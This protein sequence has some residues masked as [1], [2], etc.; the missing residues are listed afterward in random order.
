MPRNILIVVAHEDDEILG[1]GGTISR[2]IK[3]G[4]KV[5]VCFLTHDSPTRENEITDIALE[6]HKLIGIEKSFVASY[7]CM[8]LKDEYHFDIVRFIENAIRQSNADVVITHHPYDLHCDH[9]VVSKCCQEAVRL[10]QRK[11]GYNHEVKAFMYMEVKSST[12]WSLNDGMNMFVPNFFVGIN[13]DDVSKKIEI[14]KMYDNVIR[15]HP[16]SRSV[17]SIEALSI[18]RGSQSNNKYAE[19]YQLVFGGV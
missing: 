9:Q 1:C 16:H 11:I 14:L 13:K 5:S 12:D 7:E 3:E 4:H 10:P 2:C 18:Y 6:S 15:E 19:A 8:K 17:E